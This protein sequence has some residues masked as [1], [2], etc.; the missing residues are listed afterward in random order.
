MTS[1]GTTP[2]T[3]SMT[4][5]GTPVAVPKASDHHTLGTGTDDSS[6]TSLMTSNWRWRSYSGKTGTS[7]GSGA[8]RATSFSWRGAPSSVHAA[9][10]STV[11]LDMPLADAA[12]S[13]SGTV[14]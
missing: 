1:G 2:S 14:G 5:R 12:A 11:S 8:T 6:P 4:K 9:V 13:S 7:A 10:N 3:R